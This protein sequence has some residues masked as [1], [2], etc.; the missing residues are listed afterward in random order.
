MTRAYHFTEVSPGNVYLPDHKKHR[1]LGFQ[2][3]NRSP[4]IVPPGA[5]KDIAYAN[6]EPGQLITQNEV[7]YLDN[8][9]SFK[10]SITNNKFNS[11]ENNYDSHNNSRE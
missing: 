9:E 11:I 5:L 3:M 10:N 1:E 2:F 7:D 4:K 8:E 6:L